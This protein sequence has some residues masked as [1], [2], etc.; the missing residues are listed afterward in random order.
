[1]SFFTITCAIVVC[2]LSSSCVEAAQCG[3]EEE[4]D[5]AF[6]QRVRSASR[7]SLDTGKKLHYRAL[8]VVGTEPGQPLYADLVFKE[9]LEVQGFFVHL[10]KDSEA[11]NQDCEA[12][13][14]MLVSATISAAA[15]GTSVNN[16]TTPQLIWEV[17]T[18]QANAMAGP[19]TEDAW[20]TSSYWNKNHQDAWLETGYW[21]P[22]PT[23]SK[24]F[25]TEGGARDALAAGFG[26]G[27]VPIFSVEDYG[28]N[29][30][31]VNSLGRGAKVVG[32]LPPEKTSSWLKKT[33]TKIHKA[34][35]FYYEKGAEL[36]AQR[37]EV[38]KKS[39]ALRIGFPP[40]NFIYG[41]DPTCEEL[42]GTPACESCESTCSTASQWKKVDQNPTPLSCDGVK[43]LD[44]A[45]HVLKE[46][47]KKCLEEKRTMPQ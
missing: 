26:P 6:L 45:I 25:I 7:E 46:E 34:V 20:V 39:P 13:D 29:W 11:T 40:Y 33:H 24:I 30:V 28:Q 12:F 36:Y 15:L 38:A 23:G 27:Y 9:R 3:A 43:F 4:E 8:F 10:V 14:V 44:A 37:G 35:L 2:A 47:A 1:M 22:A 17:G 18:Y 41:S 42:S 16:C 19:S 31:N 21:P 32:I 5:V